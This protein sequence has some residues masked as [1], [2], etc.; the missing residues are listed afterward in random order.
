MAQKRRAGNRLWGDPGQQEKVPAYKTPAQQPQ[1]GLQ[2]KA[3]D[4][5]EVESQENP[6]RPTITLAHGAK[7]SG[8]NFSSSWHHRPSLLYGEHAVCVGKKH[9]L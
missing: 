4:Q 3:A 2:G 5:T 1:R 9:T 6:W 8:P 7:R